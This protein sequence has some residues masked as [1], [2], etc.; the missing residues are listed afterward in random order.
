[1]A[2]F[3]FG[4]IDYSKWLEIETI[5]APAI[6]KS[7][8]DIRSV[9]GRDGG[10]LA[11]NRLEPMEIKIKARL[12]TDTIDE[13]EI[14]RKWAEIAATMRHDGP[15]PLSLVEG[16]YWLAVLADEPKLKFRHYSA[17]AELL[18]LCPDP[19]AYGAEHTVEVPSGGSI[20]IKVGGSYPTRPTIG[21]SAVRDSESLVWGIRLDGGDHLHIATGSAEARSVSVDCAERTCIV[22][23]SPSLPTLDS[24]WLSFEPGEHTL[25]IDN[26]TGAATVTYRER[27]L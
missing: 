10:Y 11:S 3:I 15:E 27:W 17:T 21:S 25:E 6:A 13:R 9:A 22:N 14:Q 18:F 26:G 7:S 8:P 20:A 23:G 19:V 16:Y 2:C 24:D 5:D 4:G 1:M 12:A